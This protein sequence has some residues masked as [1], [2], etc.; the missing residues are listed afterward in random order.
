MGGVLSTQ[1]PIERK[2]PSTPFCRSLELHRAAG[3]GHLEDAKAVLDK[4]PPIDPL[5]GVN[6]ID[7]SFKTPLHR[8]AEKGKVDMICF[9]LERGAE[10]HAFTNGFK[11]PLHL[12]SRFGM[13][14]ACIC[15]LDHGADPYIKDKQDRS[16]LGTNTLT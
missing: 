7:G 6:A 10:I 11:T 5:I 13:T 3:W 14:D 9:L 8:A 4:K 16:P 2:I 1:V 15:L 12:A